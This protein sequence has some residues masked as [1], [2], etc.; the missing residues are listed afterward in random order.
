MNKAVILAAG[1]GTRMEGLTE[2]R[3]KPMI[4]LAG[5]P[6][7]EHILDRLRAAGF[8]A[9]FIVTG[10][11]AEMIESHFE[12]YP[13]SITYARQ[14]TI[15][16]TARATMLAREWVGEDAFL[17]TYGDILAEPGDY[18]A[19]GARL[20]DASIAS[21]LAVRWVDDP[22][23]GA[24]VYVEGGF[25]NERVTRI[26]E[27][28]VPGTSAT[29]WNSAGVYTFRHTIFDEMA[30]VP[31]SARGEYE[32]TSAVEQ[33]IDSG[34]RLTIHACEGAWRDVGRPGDISVAEG[35]LDG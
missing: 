25:P 21:E 10:Y 34:A 14:T 4:P 5:K 6:M 31:K 18:E 16:G 23:Q 28:P 13:M 24:A 26:V 30:R 35:M 11:K 33:L 3:P 8:D 17:L 29:R 27:K 32:L 2:D 19:M 20:D 12:G 7:L 15:D 9:V 22:W 1:R